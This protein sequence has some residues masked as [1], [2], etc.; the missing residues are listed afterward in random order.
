MEHS[1]PRPIG[2]KWQSETLT[3]HDKGEPE[4]RTAEFVVEG[5]WAGGEQI[6]MYPLSTKR[7]THVEAI[8]WLAKKA[9]AY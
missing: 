4:L 1:Y 5:N 7:L 6:V 9:V 8:A 3:C 2:T